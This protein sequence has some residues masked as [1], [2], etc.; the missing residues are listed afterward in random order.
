MSLPTVPPERFG[1]KSRS[2]DRTVIHH[3]WRGCKTRRITQLPMGNILRFPPPSIDWPSRPRL[4]ITSANSGQGCPTLTASS[5]AEQP[6]CEM[7]SLLGSKQDLVQGNH[8]APN[9]L[10]CWRPRNWFRDSA[11]W[12]LE[13]ISKGKAR[14]TDGTPFLRREPF[15]RIGFILDGVAFQVGS[16]PKSF[17]VAKEY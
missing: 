7:S 10:A 9:Q 13:W 6:I 15:N 11:S 17:L 16:D 12:N 5:N 1:L 8:N 3:L 4:G 14:K 2:V